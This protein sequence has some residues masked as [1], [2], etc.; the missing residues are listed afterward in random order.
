MSNSLRRSELVSGSP[1]PLAS[2]LERVGITIDGPAATD[3]QVHDERFYSRV[4]SGGALAFGESYVD[5]WWDVAALDEC[6]ALI[7]RN[8]GDVAV[9]PFSTQVQI[10]KSKVL[11]MQNR[12]RARRVVEDHYDLSNELYSLMLDR[13]MQYTCAYYPKA[14][15]LD[16]A[17][18][19]KLDQ[20][21]RK[22]ELKSGD[23]VLELGCGFGGFAK[24]AAER[25]GCHVTGYNISKEQL[26]WARNWTK[27]L[28]VT[29]I[30][31]DYRDAHGEF[32][33]VVSVGL[34]EHVGYK[35][36]RTLMEVA[37]RSL[38]NGGLFLLHCIGGN[39][40]RVTTDPWLE[41]YIFPGSVMPSADQLA[42]AYQ[43]LFV[44][45]DWHNFGV[46][47]DK[48]CVAWYENFNR[49]WDKIK[50]LGYDERFYRLWK[51]YLLMCAGS[52]RA[53]KNQNWEIVF[54]K[55]IY[56]GGYRAYRG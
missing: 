34:C 26:A 21:C 6:V 50:K 17:Q 24:F 10:L 38:K 55:G 47:Y 43:G 23:R 22:L 37:N 51:Y 18:E 28:P 19:H 30:E 25:Y 20:I 40:A 11:N 54:S 13:Y 53:R 48:T 41:K 36:Y 44:M 3:I 46:D 29:F 2:L 56:E 14:S 4:L 45:E 27:G 42:N 33:K 39:E 8:R 35:N 1:Y 49:N 12:S 9:V 15:N 31:R 32:D 16:E 52:F 5:G 7:L